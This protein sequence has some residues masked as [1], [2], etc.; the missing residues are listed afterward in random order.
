MELIERVAE[1]IIGAQCLGRE[2]P[3]GGYDYGHNTEFYGPAPEGGRY[4]IRDFRTPKSRGEWLHQTDDNE[5][6][7]STLKKM[8]EEHIAKAAIRA[9]L[10]GVEPV[11]FRYVHLDYAGR[12]VSRYGSHAERVNGHDPIETHPLYSLDALKEAVKP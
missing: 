9:M 6:H 7:Q 4:V 5:L 10:D 11:G 12:K 3:F 8:T 1:A 2:G